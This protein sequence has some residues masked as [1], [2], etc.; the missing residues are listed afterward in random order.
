[1]GPCKEGSS[2]RQGA[3]VTAVPP[4]AACFVF[5]LDQTLV[6]IVIFQA[7]VLHC[8]NVGTG[9]EERRETHS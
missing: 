5:A 1:M 7:V 6:R 8:K 2:T 9:G 4:A 3:N